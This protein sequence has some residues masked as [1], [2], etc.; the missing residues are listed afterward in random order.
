MNLRTMGRV[1]PE[2]LYSRQL[3]R[4][5]LPCPIP[6][7]TGRVIL[8]LFTPNSWPGRAWLSL[9]LGSVRRETNFLNKTGEP[10]SKQSGLS[11]LQTSANCKAQNKKAKLEQSLDSVSDAKKHIPN[12]DRGQLVP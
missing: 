8:K 6:G 3:T 9:L 7:D 11:R 10:R 2:T 1:V 4:Q 5:V 12:E